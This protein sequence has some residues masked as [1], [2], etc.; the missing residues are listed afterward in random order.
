VPSAI[1]AALPK[2]TI[3]YGCKITGATVTSTGSSCRR[4]LHFQLCFLRLIGPIMQ[5]FSWV[6]ALTSCLVRGKG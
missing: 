2:D 6:A 3:H 5:V 4:L 1:S